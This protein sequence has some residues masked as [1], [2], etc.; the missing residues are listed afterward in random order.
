MFIV[1]DRSFVLEIGQ[2]FWTRCHL[3]RNED[4]SIFRY[5]TLDF[6][7]IVRASFCFSLPPQI[8]RDGPDA[9]RWWL[10]SH[11]NKANTCTIS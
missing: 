4:S 9:T 1:S 6:S 3:K 7:L 10:I 2:T 8:P 11:T 5:T